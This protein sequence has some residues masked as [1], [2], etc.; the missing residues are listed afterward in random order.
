MLS[1]FHFGEHNTILYSSTAELHQLLIKYCRI[2]LK[3]SNE[4]LLVL[5][6]HGSIENFLRALKEIDGHIESRQKD[7]SIV[8]R[9]SSKAYFNLVDELVN[10]MIMLRML[11]Q[12]KKKLSKDGLTVVSDMGI[13]IHKNRI[14][15]LISHETRLSLRY[16]DD[17]EI[18]MICCYAKSD[19]TLLTQQQKQ[20]ILSTHKVL[21][22]DRHRD[23][24]QNNS[25]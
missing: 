3:S 25:W 7:G 16:D 22:Y 12:R 24:Y 14:I 6:Y 11:L 19:L 18:K 5:T 23:S 21:D 1:D 20:Q 9:E 10:I 8:I 15:D 2:S 13:F 4:I 17:N